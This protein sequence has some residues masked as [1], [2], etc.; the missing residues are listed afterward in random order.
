MHQSIK[1]IAASHERVAKHSRP[2]ALSIEIQNFQSY[3]TPALIPLSSLTVVCGPNSAGK[4]VILDAIELLQG[5][6]KNMEDGHKNYNRWLSPNNN[7]DY[8]TDKDNLTQLSVT[9]TAG[10]HSRT[11]PMIQSI[12][13]QHTKQ[14]GDFQDWEDIEF[15]TYSLFHNADYEL[16]DELYKSFP[17]G[18]KG[19]IILNVDE[20]ISDDLSDAYNRPRALYFKFYGN[21]GGGRVIELGIEGSPIMAISSFNETSFH[22]NAN[23]PLLTDKGIR[24]IDEE[25]CRQKLGD[26]WRKFGLPAAESK[27][28]KTIGSGHYWVFDRENRIDTDALLGSD[29][30]RD[31]ITQASAMFCI[32]SQLIEQALVLTKIPGVRNFPNNPIGIEEKTLDGSDRQIWTTLARDL[33]RESLAKAAVADLNSDLLEKINISLCE[34]L[35]KNYGL[36]LGYRL[37]VSPVLSL[38]VEAV[39]SLGRSTGNQNNFEFLQHYLNNV[40]IQVADLHGRSLDLEDVGTGVSQVIPVLWS[41]IS[42]SLKGVVHIQQ[43][44]LH[45]HPALQMRLADQFLLNRE[46]KELTWIIETHSEHF[47]LRI[48]KRI[49]QTA[50]LGDASPIQ[51]RPSD[52][53][54]LYIWKDPEYG[55]RVAHMKITSDGDFE[56]RWPH[57]FFEERT[58]EWLD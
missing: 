48:L 9:F 38:P 32:F 40:S 10:S 21:R 29:C 35:Y 34:G 11:W 6:A 46:G 45:L 2:L 13:I 50:K 52:V 24:E 20:R 47:I 5:V 36:D 55:S 39:L 31:L 30:E 19:E 56:D 7:D 49:R 23:H 43:P 42:P 41:A 54:V 3:R 4:S 37:I 44:E 51:I 33:A 8:D 16:R 12:L 27:E 26:K 14:Y 17:R 25:K 1:N 58:D 15:A 57:G 22:F 28:F 53:V 18:P